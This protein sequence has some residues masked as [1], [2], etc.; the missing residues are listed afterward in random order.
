MH[1]HFFFVAESGRWGGGGG[2]HFQTVESSLCTLDDKRGMDGG[3]RA[4]RSCTNRPTPA[5]LILPETAA[6]V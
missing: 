3:A 4:V 5:A 6:Y 1:T 2:G